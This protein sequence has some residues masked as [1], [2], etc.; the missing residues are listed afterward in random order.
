VKGGIDLERVD[1]EVT[2]RTTGGSYW[3][4][5]AASPA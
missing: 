1:Y 4:T 2:Q 3:R 5:E